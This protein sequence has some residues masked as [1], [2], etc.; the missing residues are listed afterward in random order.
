MSCSALALGPALSFNETTFNVLDRDGQYWLQAADIAR[1]LGYVSDNAISRI[2]Q[3]RSDEFTERMCQKVNLTFSQ[4]GGQLQ[5]ESRIF[6]LRGAHLVA[7]FAR[8]P[9][10]KEFRR[11]VLDILD[12]EVAQS[13]K[14][15]RQGIAHEQAKDV[16][17]QIE[18][19][20]EQLASVQAKIVEWELVDA[21]PP[22]SPRIKGTVQQVFRDKNGDWLMNVSCGGV[23][24]NISVNNTAM[25]LEGVR[26]G[27]R[28]YVEYKKGDNP[29]TGPYTGVRLVDDE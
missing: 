5:R 28:V 10:A 21:G 16:L 2:Y 19:M 6:S 13:G 15:V 14:P 4:N 17:A 20:R 23:C 7:M 3:R 22:P 18:V 1:A 25:R 27:D 24:L 29:L 26:L 9:I 11:W 12:R 8:T